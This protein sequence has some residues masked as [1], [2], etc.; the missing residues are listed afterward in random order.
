MKKL[1][2]VFAIVF[3]AFSC[4]RSYNESNAIVYDN[5]DSQHQKDL[6]TRTKET[7][8]NVNKVLSEK[9]AS[10]IKGY[11]ARRKWQMQVLEGVFI[12]KLK[13]GNGKA[14]T[15]SSSVLLE[16]TLGLLT[17]ETIY[18]SAKDGI[19]KI[20]FGVSDNEPT[21]LLHVLQTLKF[22]DE[23]NIVIPSYLGYGLYGDGKKIKAHAALVYYIKVVEVK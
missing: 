21:G 17:G 7:L 11:I 14:I 19:K 9:E 2:Y 8:L 1:I 23:A 16:Y 18:T 20:T 6:N 12:E 13:Q 15:D 22:G 3:L 10:Q 5:T 4:S